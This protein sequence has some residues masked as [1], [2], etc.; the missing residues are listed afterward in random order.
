M[1]PN[2]SF[3]DTAM[4]RRMKLLEA[5]QVAQRRRQANIDMIWNGVFTLAMIVTVA[6]GFWAATI[7]GSTTLAFGS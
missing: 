3:T 5:R 6:T 2:V 7:I 1:N 4:G